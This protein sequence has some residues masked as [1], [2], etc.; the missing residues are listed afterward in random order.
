MIAQQFM[1]EASEESF[2]T[3]VISDV[4]KRKKKKNPI[5]VKRV[6]SVIPWKV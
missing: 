6:A 5:V 3:R 2:V 4:C 1:F